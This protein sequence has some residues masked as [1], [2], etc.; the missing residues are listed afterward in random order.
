MRTATTTAAVSI[1]FLL[2]VWM[3]APAF[4]RAQAPDQTTPPP[5]P[6]PSETE[7]TPETPA[8]APPPPPVVD[9]SAPPPID[10][11]APPPFDAATPP[12]VLANL[13]WEGLVDTYYL[14]K[15]TGASGVEDPERRV[16]D[17]LGN[18]FSLAYAKLALQMDADPVGLRVDF[19]Y[20]H[21]GS[22]INDSSQ[23][24]SDPISGLPLYAG[25]FI[26]QQAYATARFGI[27][28]FDAGKFNTTAGAEVTE[29]NRN[30]LYSRSLLFAG[31]PALHTG[32]RLTLKPN[33]TI[34]VQASLVN[35]GI[36]NNDPDNNAWKT[37][38][39]SLGISPSPATLLALTSYFGKEGM[40]LDQGNVQMLLDLVVGQ[41][42]GENLA[43]NLNVDY[44]KDG[45]AHWIGASVMGR[46]VLTELLY[47]ALR[48]EMISSRNGG[49]VMITQNITLFE[50]T[51][52]AGLPIAPNY[53]IRLELRGDFA[54]RD[55]F[56]KGADARNNQLTG[57]AAFLASF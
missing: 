13:K 44:F 32:L 33:E 16:F 20:G 43:L 3:G 19:G 24:G 39:L 42:F 52:M 25:A 41:S 38:G 29:S 27:A 23:I 37:V 55:L 4:T 45:S 8:P 47:L 12:S 54:D 30:W 2:V 56:H 26:V 7:A 15:L 34:S 48:G 9:P 6:P 50:A 18:S 53:E 35:G 31:I 11:P 40:P 17:T 51:L 10:L 14:Y 5:P 46:F 28:T 36:T 1:T 57:L 21:V 49:Y 22:L